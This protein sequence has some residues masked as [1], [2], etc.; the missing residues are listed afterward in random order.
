M[1]AVQSVVDQTYP[2]ASLEIVVVDDG[3]T[4]DTPA[5]LA[6]AFGDRV[7]LIH[8]P[9]GGVSS[10]RNVGMRAARGAYL[11]LLDSDDEWHPTKIARQVEFLDAHPDFGMVVTDIEMVTGDRVA[12][13]VFR[14]RDQIPEDGMALASVLRNPALAPSSAMFR[15]EVIDDVGGFDEGLPTAED[16]DFHLRVA[17]RWPI[18]VVEEPLTRAMRGHDGL[19]ALARTYGDYLTVFET[20]VRDHAHLIDPRDRDAALLEA[21]ARNARGLLWCGNV[22]EALRVTAKGAARVRGGGDARKVAALG[23]D[24]ARGLAA[25]ARRRL[26]GRDDV[27]S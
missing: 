25:R 23:F 1:V 20:F 11:A 26:L 12:F 2:A 3:G 15:R 4:D 17:L 16:I 14:R 13:N 24:L 7:R 22:A 9:N 21:Y 6:E 18:G 5:L 27:E 8:K 10:A 19:S